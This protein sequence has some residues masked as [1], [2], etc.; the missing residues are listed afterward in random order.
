MF[1]PTK[2]EHGAQ[3][4]DPR[5]LCWH[6]AGALA[7]AFCAC[8]SPTAGLVSRLAAACS[9]N[10]LP[11]C[12]AAP[13]L[14]VPVAP[15]PH[16]ALPPF[17]QMGRSSPRHQ[18]RCSSRRCGTC[19]CSALHS[20]CHLRRGR[21]CRCR[22]GSCRGSTP[23]RCSR[24]RPRRSSRRSGGRGPPDSGSCSGGGSSSGRSNAAAACWGTSSGSSCWQ[25]CCCRWC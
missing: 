6:P 10:P 11:V 20:C 19:G 17:P 1:N 8:H 18:R 23:Q 16:P 25:R 4:S 5:S 15:A 3:G 9:T 22:P 12:Q 21:R 13:L 7:T 14:P 24:G 2:A